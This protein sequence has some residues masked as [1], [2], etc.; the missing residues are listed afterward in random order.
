MEESYIFLHREWKDICSL[1]KDNKIIN[2]KN[3]ENEKGKFEIIEQNNQKIIK[4]KWDKWNGENHFI[5][6]NEIPRNSF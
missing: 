1:N 6:Y 4:I 3:I 2:R 5:F